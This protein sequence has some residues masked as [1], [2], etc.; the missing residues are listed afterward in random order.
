M[1]PQHLHRLGLVNDTIL[2]VNTSRKFQKRDELTKHNSETNEQTPRIRERLQ[3]TND[4]SNLSR[5]KTKYHHNLERE[6]LKTEDDQLETN[7]NV[8]EKTKDNHLF[9]ESEVEKPNVGV[10]NKEFYEKTDSESVTFEFENDLSSDEILLLK[11]ALNKI[12]QIP[13]ALVIDEYRWKYF[14]GAIDRDS[15]NKVFWDLSLEL[16]G[17]APP[18][19]RSEE[20]FDIG[21]KFH[22]PDN[23]P[24]IR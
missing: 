20:Y 6:L 24:Y 22:I 5:G 13:F 3:K 17:I 18:A 11:Q 14:E 10:E 8:D 23:T 1:T 21:A 2:Y 19:E 9:K 15:L 7:Q 4:D 16:Q 12:P